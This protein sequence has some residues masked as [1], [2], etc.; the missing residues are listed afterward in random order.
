LF[1]CGGCRR[2]T[3]AT[4]G[5]IFQDTRKPLVMWFRAMWYVTSQKNGGLGPLMYLR[6]PVAPDDSVALV[7]RTQRI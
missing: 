4:G 7:L 5:T 3:S 2:Q 6:E 1:Q